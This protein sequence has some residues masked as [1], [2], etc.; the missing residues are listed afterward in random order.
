MTLGLPPLFWWE[1]P[2]RLAA[3]D[4][5][6]QRLRQL[7]AAAR[8]LAVQD[9]DL[10]QHDGRQPG[11][12]RPG[13]GQARHRVLSQPR[14]Q[15]QGRQRSTTSPSLMLKE[16]L[17]QLPVVR[18]DIPDPWIHGMLSMPAACKLAHNIRPVDRG[19]RPIDNAG[20]VLGDLSSRHPPDRSPPPTSR[21]CG[22]AN[23]RGGWPISITSSSPSARRGMNSGGRACRRSIQ[24]DGGIVEREG[25]L[26]GR[27]GAAG[28]RAVCRRG[29]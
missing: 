12:A 16:D 17:S 8:Q 14:H 2:G 7:A 29:R 28:C 25:R 1:G 20:K 19:A 13:H 10:H 21:A 15:G 9:L 27:S 23:T 18:S 4:A 22:S 6:Q 26:R 11:S 3:A 24:V 5:L